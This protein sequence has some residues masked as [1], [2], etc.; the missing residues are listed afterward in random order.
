[1]AGKEATVYVVDCGLTM[2]ERS[3]GRSE[4]NLEWALEYVWDKIT[5]TV[6]TGRKTAMAGVVGFRTDGTSNSLGEQEEY[7][8]VSIF[9]DIGQLLMPQLR[10]LSNDV[11]VSQTNTGD[12]ISALVIAIHMIAQT[13]R[14]LKYDRK[15]VLVTDGRGHMATDDLEMISSKLKEDG[16]QLIVLGVDFDDEEYGYKEEAKDAVKFENEE[17][18]RKFCE[19]LGELGQFGTLAEAVDELQTPR[20]KSVKPVP[21]YKGYLTLGNPA[22]YDTAL[23]I[24]VERYPKIMVARPPTA[25]SFVVRN[26]MAAGEATQSSANLSN[27][28]GLAEDGAHG[29]LSSVKS[30]RTY[31]VQDENAPG[32]KK[33]LDRDELSKGYEYGRT[34]VHISE[35]DWNVTMYETTPGFDIVGFVDKKKVSSS[36]VKLPGTLH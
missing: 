19:D 9:Q 29:G 36:C 20:V 30:A 18:L 23:S 24:D 26:D 16:T 3:H 28:E 7:Q 13:C 14:K 11:K 6:A 4:T 17:I 15:V 8:H 35:S 25:S 1:M 34:A 33:E 2:G 27:G 5:S 22:N 31:T 32:G 10:Q 12:A 21:S